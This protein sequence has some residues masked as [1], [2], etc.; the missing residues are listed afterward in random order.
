MRSREHA[1]PKAAGERGDPQPSV[2]NQAATEKAGRSDPA[3]AATA[4]AGLSVSAVN[5]KGQN[6]KLQA[7]HAPPVT[8]RLLSSSDACRHSALLHPCPLNHQT[9][10]PSRRA[11]GIIV[12]VK[13]F[14]LRV[15]RLGCKHS[16][17]RLGTFHAWT[18]LP[19]QRLGSRC[20]GQAKAS[21]ARVRAVAHSPKHR[22]RLNRREEGR[23]VLLLLLRVLGL[24]RAGVERGG[25]R[26]G[27]LRGHSG[28]LDRKAQRAFRN[29]G[30]R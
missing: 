23:G 24:A 25:G 8:W 10:E 22:G 19:E 15:C 1:G 16:V 6:A 9:S 12:M 21:R 27:K 30:G 14:A 29:G 18:L 5:Q 28:T 20:S 26:G 3:S 7:R 17:R 2:L 4:R 11:I 13:P